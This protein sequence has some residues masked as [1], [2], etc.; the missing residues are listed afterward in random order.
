MKI[1]N[2]YLI[3]CVSFVL[4]MLPTQFGCKKTEFEL[5]PEQ[6]T[7][8]D[9]ERVEHQEQIGDGNPVYYY[10]ASSDKAEMGGPVP[11]DIKY[12]ADELPTSPWRTYNGTGSI[13][14]GILTLTQQGGASTYADPFTSGTL[15]IRMRVTEQAFFRMTTGSGSGSCGYTIGIAVKSNGTVV[16]NHFGN[17]ITISG[18]DQ[19]VF[20][21]Y[22]V[23]ITS[24]KAKLYIDGVLKAEGMPAY[25]G[26][27]RLISFQS[28]N[29]GETLHKPNYFDYVYYTTN[30]AYVPV[31]TLLAKGDKWV[32]LN[33]DYDWPDYDEQTIYDHLTWAGKT[34]ARKSV[35]NYWVKNKLLGSNIAKF[36]AR[37]PG[38]SG[39]I[40]YLFMN[41]PIA[42]D[43]DE[44]K[45]V[46][47]R[48]SD[49]YTKI[50]S[51]GSSYW[52]NSSYSWF[53]TATLIHHGSEQYDYKLEL[54]RSD[55]NRDIPIKLATAVLPYLSCAEESTMLI[56]DFDLKIHYPYEY[57][58][59]YLWRKG[60]G[61]PD[62]QY[63]HYKTNYIQRYN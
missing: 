58:C 18:I 30:G 57:I 11:W 8:S 4:L 44:V 21:T 55:P 13:N 35:V 46:Y 26:G 36:L 15:E 37:G 28:H 41:L 9:I 32:L 23:T 42:G 63:V 16:F 48:E 7:E 51:A 25:T 50:K 59:V 12:K 53:E 34:V 40:A 62:S 54:Y 3:W 1:K 52:V 61:A 27:A 20:H 49:G 10:T 38:V 33:N 2:Y 24:T 6:T 31:P 5:Q 47:V 60:S 17:Q 43:A 39:V 56:W 14:E 19:S 45:Q 29:S 22:R